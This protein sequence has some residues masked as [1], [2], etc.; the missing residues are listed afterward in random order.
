MNVR[1][2]WKK[3]KETFRLNYNQCLLECSP[4][5]VDCIGAC[6]TNYNED[7]QVC[8]CQSKC[9]EGCPCPEYNCVLQRDQVLILSTNKNVNVPIITNAAGD[10]KRNFNFSI[11]SDAQVYG[12]CSLTWQNEVY[13]LGGHNRR[14]QISKITSCRLEPVGQLPFDHYYGDCLSTADNQVYVCFNADSDDLYRCRVASSPYGLFSEI[15]SSY[16]AHFKIRIATDDGK[17]LKFIHE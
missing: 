13:I 15:T 11:D 7:I 2:F 1:T 10:V 12:S 8:P 9:P 5:D 16:Y 3:L 17:L 6:L 4:A 14:T